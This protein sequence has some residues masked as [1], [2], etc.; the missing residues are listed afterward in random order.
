MSSDR[1]E[2]QKKIGE[3]GAGSVYLAV[4]T[5]LD[6]EVAIK[7]LMSE[8][9]GK[10]TQ[11]TVDMMLKEARLLSSI[12]HPNIV[13]IYDAD[14][15]EDGPYVVMEL[16]QGRNMDELIAEN[17]MTAA[18]FKSF[19]SHCLDALTAAHSINVIHRDIKPNNIVLKWLP[20]G[21][22]QAKLLDFGMAKLSQVPTKQTVDHGGSVMGSIYFMAPEQFER[23]E[24]DARTD[25]YALG[26][27]F[28]YTLTGTYP[29][30]GETPAEV[31]AAHLTH[32]VQPIAELRPDLPEWACN[33]IMW[34]I[35][36][37]MQHRPESAQVALDYF[38][39]NDDEI[40]L[41]SSSS[42]KNIEKSTGV[43]QVGQVSAATLTPQQP[44]TP[45]GIAKPTL[46]TASG[47]LSKASNINVSVPQ[48]NITKPQDIKATASTPPSMLNTGT[49]PGVKLVT[50]EQPVS[51]QTSP[52]TTATTE[53]NTSPTGVKLVTGAQP[54]LSQSDTLP[55]KS[56]TALNNVQKKTTA[57]ETASKEKE[58]ANEKSPPKK[59][60]NFIP[61]III[62]VLA[63]L[64][65]LWIAFTQ[66]AKNKVIGQYNAL[67]TQA[68]GDSPELTVTSKPDLDFLLEKLHGANTKFDSSNILRRLLFAETDGTYDIG[69]EIATF[70]TQEGTLI[71][72]ETRSSLLSIVA[73]KNSEPSV[74]TL[75]DY[76]KSSDNSELIVD[77]IRASKGGATFTH[78]D[79]FTNLILNTRI[80]KARQAAEHVAGHIIKN[81]KQRV[82]VSKVITDA[83]AN[84]DN[85]VT[86]ASITRLIGSLGGEEAS[87]I[88]TDALN[89]GNPDA[90]IPALGAIKEWKDDTML[91][92]TIDFW[93]TSPDE[94][95]RKTAFDTLY[96]LM[97]RFHIKQSSEKTQEL[98]E[99]IADST[100][101]ANE[102]LLVIN[103]MATTNK[104]YSQTIIE[105]FTND[106]DQTVSKRAAKAL[107]Y[108][109]GKN[110]KKD[111]TE[112]KK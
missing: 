81:T 85:S 58:Q 101:S 5:R 102:K 33:W 82:T 3:G 88:I 98:W 45:A 30:T 18:D 6:R 109:V 12:D 36:R 35:N 15:D 55:E 2:I 63:V 112:D 56:K 59:K 47:S 84:A 108:L 110:E 28:Y 20:N 52:N 50:G 93:N 105:Q 27:V 41:R 32:R 44:D 69:N 4:D 86:K 94:V 10:W 76:I 40:P 42:D 99:N 21:K 74:T 51:K 13:T 49:S 97:T 91:N 89:S 16:L 1:Y 106:S 11:S 96:S 57:K 8:E 79:F 25:I 37:E 17:P 62:S 31:M 64:A 75:I 43:I 7:R 34:L 65:G 54:A 39:A 70:A 38:Q 71:S 92:T 46:L 87:A 66:L 80:A 23:I 100:Q 95:I 53:T 48:E 61:L 24:L 104:P 67:I 73:T 29:F 90:V 22:F 68:D 26:A 19:A 83:I 107:E 78:L 14:V 111:E 60:A 77:S 103:A 9:D 72:D